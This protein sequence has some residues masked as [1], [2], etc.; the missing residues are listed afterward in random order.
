MGFAISKTRTTLGIQALS[1][2]VEVHLS[3]GLPAFHIVGLPETAVKESKDRVRSALMNSQFDFPAG[4]ITVNLSP[5][6]IPKSGSSFD[7]AIAIA[8]LAAT[9][10]IPKQ[11]LQT[12]EFIAELGLDGQLHRVQA[13]IPM[14]LAAKHDQHTLIIAS[15]NA[16]EASIIDNT[17]LL[18]GRTLREV[19]RYLCQ[20]EA[21]S[22]AIPLQAEAKIS[23]SLDWS[24]VKGQAHAKKAMKIAASGGHSL[25]LSGPPGS[26]KTML[27]K[28][29]TTILP[30]LTETEMLEHAA[31]HSVYGRRIQ[32]TQLRHPPFRAPHHSASHVALVGGGNP[33]KPGEISLAHRG[34][35]FL[36]E[37]PEFQRRT[38]ETLREPLESGHISISR[39][40]IQMEFPAQFQLIAAMNPCPCG[41]HGH[42]EISCDCSPEQIRRYQ[43]KLSGP[44]LD[45][46]DIQVSVSALTRQELLAVPEHEETSLDIQAHIMK[47]QEIQ[48]ARQ[49]VLNAHLSAKAC[50]TQCQLGREEHAFLEHALSR[51]RLSARGFHRCLKVAR[52]I[53]DYNFKTTVTSA[54]L[55]QALSYRQ[56]LGSFK[57]S[58]AHVQKDQTTQ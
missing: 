52:T 14:A 36:D 26:G 37:F 22:R 44:I 1:I 55:K 6:H 10:Q 41:Y 5:A 54:E 2:L 35:L 47:I 56:T 58:M 23:P 4:R 33:P 3:P 51:L 30:E 45:R 40:G 25:L 8:I 21:L 53:A 7:L 32:T 34:V 42:Q 16:E 38:I 12:H 46:I 17:R 19:C 20:G 24:E 39:A 28:R 29:F 57:S 15:S 27:A 49:G 11:A 50:E 31:I 48:R 18:L 13:I 43:K 9:N